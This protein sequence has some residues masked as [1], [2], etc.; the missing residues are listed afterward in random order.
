MSSTS[1][2]VVLLLGNPNVGKSSLYNALTGG[3]ARVANYPGLTV[4]R[5]SGQLLPELSSDLKVSIV[6]T[7]G[8][9]SVSARSAEEQIA[10]RALLGLRGEPTPDALIVVLDAG[11]LSRCLYLTLELLELRIKTVLAI[12]MIDEVDGLDL[13][14]LEK[15]LGVPCVGTNATTGQGVPELAER[16]RAELRAERPPLPKLHV[17]Y[18]PEIIRALD[19]VSDALPEAWLGASASVERKRAL[20]QFALGS[21]DAEDELED[22][23]DELRARVAEVR[24]DS[25]DLDLAIVSARYQAIDEVLAQISSPQATRRARASERVDRF[26]LHPLLGTLTFIIVMTTVFQALFVGADP[27]I[28]ALESLVGWL[29]ELTE[30]LLPEGI[31]RDFLSQGIIGGVGNVI[32]FLPQICLLFLF[33]G[34]L[35]DSG[36]M[37]RIAYLADRIM[38][39]LGLHGRAFVPM[40]SGFACAVP[41]ILSTRT[42][43]RRRDRLLTMM[44][45]P[46]MTCSARLPV[47]SLIIA[48]LFPVTAFG[49]PVQGLLLLAMYLFALFTA[50]LAAFVLSRTVLHGPSVPLLLELPAYRMPKVKPLLQVVKRKAGQFLQEA[51]G[52]ILVAT[53]VLWALLSFP[54]VS[55][56]A[57]TASS[58][59]VLFVD[60]HTFDQPLTNESK[61]AAEGTAAAEAANG[62]AA[63]EAPEGLC[64]A[65]ITQSYGGRISKALEPAL[66]PLG[67]D[68]KIGTGILGAFAAREVFV[69]T[70]ALVYGIEGDDE[71]AEGPLRD[72]LRAERH[73]DGSP[74]YTPLMGLSLMVFFALACQ[75]VSTLAV[76]RR[77]TGGF[78]YPLFV[79]GYMTALAY[80]ASFL[81]YQGGRALGF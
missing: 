66:A 64:P 3:S 36:Y 27:A 9:Y 43:E 21:I 71:E 58:D 67:F 5:K 10:I 65:P 52:T 72:K 8:T 6:D 17:P 15:S 80:G 55:E 48:A 20:A 46:L 49:L 25:E 29:Q 1:D 39:S 24:A 42:L 13:E 47:Y 35:E 11:Q 61:S 22:V 60:S 69:S 18:G 19:R 56:D 30:E 28:S 31:V 41:A 63:A 74:V 62:T 81:V 73:A 78:K 33:M 40:L 79:F 37:A 54:R 2:K 16:L 75:C 53:V 32:V 38:R 76:I 7:P 57:C 12:N 26:L 51:G 45:V 44:V 34:I 23:P 59:A 50:L 68:W 77:E 4:E 70:L 14:A